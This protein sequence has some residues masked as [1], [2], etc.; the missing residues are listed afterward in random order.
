[1]GIS[2]V[3]WTQPKEDLGGN[4]KFGFVMFNNIMKS[5]KKVIWYFTLFPLYN[6]YDNIFLNMDAW[7]SG[8]ETGLIIKAFVLGSFLCFW[9]REASPGYYFSY[10][11]TI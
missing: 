9:A 8:R 7:N 5:D 11:N 10:P 6:S 1:M 2:K 3:N 4:F